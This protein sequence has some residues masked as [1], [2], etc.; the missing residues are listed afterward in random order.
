MRYGKP[1]GGLRGLRPLISLFLTVLTGVATAQEGMVPD[2]MGGRAVYAVD[3]G[4]GLG[5]E[6][7]WNAGERW[8]IRAGV[9]HYSDKQDHLIS[10]I[11]FREQHER[12]DVGLFLDRKLAGDSGWYVTAGVIHPGKGSRWD[13]D[14]DPRMG[15]TLNGRQYAGVH[16]SEPVGEVSYTALAPYTGVGWRSSGQ[17][18]W[19]A[20]AEIGVMAGLDPTFSLH[21]G[22]PYQLPYLEQDLQAEADK[23]LA[24]TQASTHLSGEQQ[25]S[26]RISLSYAF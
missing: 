9:D 1:C 10:L 18:G 24:T 2:A 19:Q 25:L 26:A 4:S 11:R 3:S 8:R 5:A 15:Y 20:G 16:L 7:A 14:P 12:S 13:A 17:Q 23:Y 6:L 22:N 21:T